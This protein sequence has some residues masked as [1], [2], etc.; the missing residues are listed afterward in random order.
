MSKL[1]AIQF[2]VDWDK[3]AKKIGQRSA[4]SMPLIQ[5]HQVCAYYNIGKGA[6]YHRRERISA[7]W[8]GYEWHRWNERRLRALCNYRWVTW[9]G[10]GASAKSCD[11]AVMGLEFWLQ[12][13]DRTAVVVCSTTMKMLRKRIWNYFANYH[14][15]LPKHLGPVGELLDSDTMIR[16]EKGNNVAGVFGMAVEE[17]PVDEVI[18]NL[19]GIHPQRYLLVLDEAQGVREAIMGATTNMA[20]NP[21]FGG[22][23]IGNPDDMQNPL[24]RESEPIGGWGN[25]VDKAF[26]GEIEEWETVGGATKGRGLC[27]FFDGRKSPADDS[28]KER[29][30]L[31]FLINAEW[32]EAHL[33]GVRG[34]END[35]SY[36]SQAIGLPP[37]KGIVSTVL[38]LATVLKFRCREPAVWTRGFF[39]WASLDPSFEGG[40]KRVLT[41]GRCGET[42]HD[43]HTR[44]VIGVDEQ[45]EV[46][47]DVSSKEP[48]HYQ[49]VH[50]VVAYLTKLG[51][52]PDSFALDSTGEG[53]GLKAIFDQTWGEVTGVE[54]GGSPSD[55]PVQS[56]P[57]VTA[58]EEYDR[59]SSELNFN[60]REFAQGNGLR[61]LEE[62]AEKDLC[63]RRTMF[64]GKKY[65]VEPKTTRTGEKGFKQRTGRSPD[66][67]DSLAIGVALCLEKGAVPSVMDA[68]APPVN[69]RDPYGDE[70]MA[71]E[72]DEFSEAHYLALQ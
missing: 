1:P 71:A 66:Y 51:I 58:R 12:A 4:D 30:R 40:D 19:I 65:C 63:E 27:Q 32:R 67:G 10:P 54:F 13:P 2:G 45:A 35:P 69:Q 34:N 33:K 60:V 68:P 20:K 25:T 46:P 29:E 36:W 61:G 7:L 72:P 6:E 48:I 62:S 11:A 70:A 3:F 24:L 31:G 37:P 15:K 22:L 5:R 28:P 9:L 47:I 18:N 17:G 21:W 43:G 8:P 59:R 16:W 14:A 26:H 53:G 57:G 64:K 23:L 44:W 42:D 52:G 41:I 50:W 49:I 55:T 56:K 38:D 39:L